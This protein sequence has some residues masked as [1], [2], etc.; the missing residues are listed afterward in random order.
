MAKGRHL[1][2]GPFKGGFDLEEW[3]IALDPERD[4]FEHGAGGYRVVFYVDEELVR[5]GSE[6]ELPR[7]FYV[8]WDLPGGPLTLGVEV[9]EY[10]ELAIR[11]A[12]VRPA[13]GQSSITTTRLRGINVRTLREV[14]GPRAAL[15]VNEDGTWRPAILTEDG[16]EGWQAA[17]RGEA[18]VPRRGKRLGRDHFERVAEL[19]GEGMALGHPTKHIADRLHT[20]RSNA[21]RWVMEARRLGLLGASPG[22]GRS[23]A[24]P[25]REKGRAHKQAK[26]EGAPT[27]GSPA[28]QR[29]SRHLS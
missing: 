24:R 6:Y 29:E 10:G 13:E 9:D 15:R 18:H 17:Y 16:K 8:L 23:G 2:L 1:V 25:I 14:I 3:G 7:R 11:S 19:Y 4:S 22:R 12:L 28:Q 27:V 20:S 21:G 5:F 26:P